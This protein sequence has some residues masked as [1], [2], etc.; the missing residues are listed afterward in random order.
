MILAL[1]VGNSNIKMGLYKNK[2]MIQYAR[3]ATEVG[4]TS[5]EY[6]LMLMNVFAYAGLDKNKVN[7]AIMASVVPSINYTMEHMIRTFFNIDTLAVGPGTK[8]GMNILYDNP[9]EVGSDRIVTAIAAFEKTKGPCIIIDF[10]TA[11]TFGAVNENGSFLGGA[12]MPGIKISMD[13]LVESSAKLPKIELIR[14]DKAIGRNTITNMQSGIINGFVGAVDNIA[15]LMRKELG[16]A[17]VIATG[18]LARLI[19][20]LTNCID[21][22]DGKLALKGLITVYERN[23]IFQKE[24]T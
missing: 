24:K 19:A 5:D 22:T 15:S 23:E 14:P 11:T 1:D 6:G 10:G 4:K 17:K 7:G 9:K 20:P 3:F 8:T 2:K 16:T 13:A 12:I 18:G 21:E